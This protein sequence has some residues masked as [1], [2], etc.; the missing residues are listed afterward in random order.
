MDRYEETPTTRRLTRLARQLGV[1]EADQDE[2]V[3]IDRH[4]VSGRQYWLGEGI[5]QNASDA[6]YRIR[7]LG[8]GKASLDHLRE[9][10]AELTPATLLARRQSLGLTQE[11]LAQRLRVTTTTVARWERGEQPLP[12]MLSLAL[13]RL[14]SQAG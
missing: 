4:P 8:K 14:E 12:G 1:I 3:L 2:A 11:Q 10:A 9:V 6:E 7:Q 5:G 13:E